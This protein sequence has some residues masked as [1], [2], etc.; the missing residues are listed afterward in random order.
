MTVASTAILNRATNLAR[1]PSFLTFWAGQTVSLLGSQISRLALPLTAVLVLQATPQQMGLIGV[2]QNAPWILV[3]L[4][5]GVLVDRLSRRR[6]MIA[7][8]LARCL[9]LLIVPAC[10][11]LGLL[12]LE[13]L[14]AIGFLT[15]LGAIF[16]RVAHESFLPSLVGSD[17]LVDGNS[18][19]TLSR[20]VADVAGP[21][22]AG[23]LVQT[24]TAPMA[25]V[26]DACS[27]AVS[28]G[29]LLFVKARVVAPPRPAARSP[30]WKD[31]RE[32]IAFVARD[33]YLRPAVLYGASANF[34]VEICLTVYVL[35]VTRELGLDAALLGVVLALG[36]IG[37]LP[38]SLLAARLS[39]RWGIGP[40]IL[41]GSLSERRDDDA[42]ATRQG[43][44][45]VAIAGCRAALPGHSVRDRDHQYVQCSAGGAAGA[46]ARAGK[47]DAADRRLGDTAPGSARRR[48]PWRR[49]R[50]A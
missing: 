11:L 6:V 30:F 18:K 16:F 9:L 48:L 27:F 14:L 1:D 43:R 13:L 41:V 2:A 19:L 28:A 50:S 32:G 35:F 8:D 47:R 45:D 49:D 4:F 3:P 23:A 29:S 25:V 42:N 38:G 40:T 15:S 10:A 5:A 33:P 44:L 22:L 34:C 46:S 26:V 21:G 17:K 39:R 31:L 37:F 36:G 24:I 12:R 7:A 20:S